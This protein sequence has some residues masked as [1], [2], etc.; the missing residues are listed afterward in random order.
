MAEEFYPVPENPEYNAAAIRKIQD[1]DPVQASTIINPVV[2]QMISN[3]HAVKKQA[4]QNDQN[5][6][7]MTT[8][9][10]NPEATY[11]A[12]AYCIY[13]GKLYKAQVNISEP[14]AWTESHWIV[15]SVG[16]EL[17][18]LD[19]ALSNKAAMIDH[20]G[21]STDALGPLADGM[22]RGIAWESLPAEAQDKQGYIWA[23]DYG[24]SD[25]VVQWGRRTFTSPHDGVI[26]INSCVV[27]TWLG[28]KMLAT[29]TSPQ[30][31]DLPLAEGWQIKNYAKYWVNQASEVSLFFRV[32]KSNG[33]TTQGVISTL[34]TGFRPAVPVHAAAISYP[35][36]YPA[37]LVVGTDGTITVFCNSTESGDDG[38]FCGS[39]SFVAA[40]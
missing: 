21:K 16:E 37:L 12:G 40:N 20:G 18:E 32:G 24:V 29:A 7:T 25:G 14:E 33:D 26:W 31:F 17:Q 27:G 4:D 19:A 3:T 13:N 11:N 10:Y 22:H 39:V 1:T 9:A 28:W 34:P 15:T 38:S 23:E 30:Q 2:Q 5:F 8:E 6:R 36:L 35:S